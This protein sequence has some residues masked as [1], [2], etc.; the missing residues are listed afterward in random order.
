MKLPA[1]GK[2]KRLLPA[3]LMIAAL[4]VA[5][6]ACSSPEPTP[7]PTPIPPTATPVPPTSTP[8]PPTPTPVP[9]TATPEPE[10]ESGGSES[11]SD[12]DVTEEV[13]PATGLVPRDSVCIE[14]HTDRDTADKVFAATG[15]INSG[16]GLKVEHILDLLDASASL[17]HCGLMP[18]SIAPV[19]SQISRDDAE[20]VIGETGVERL[21]S[22]FTITAEQQEQSLNLMALSPLIGALQACEVSIDLSAGR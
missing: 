1:R 10:V 21:V 17:T 22:F 14:E 18:R 19:V 7:T 15:A 6:V 20:C 12:V 13:D 5:I 16:A 9:P 4:G 8:V 11:E 3:V 2:V